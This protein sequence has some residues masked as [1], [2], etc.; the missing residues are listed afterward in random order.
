MGRAEVNR[1][2]ELNLTLPYLGSARRTGW[3]AVEPWGCWT[4]SR[5]ATLTFATRLPPNTEVAIY[6]SLLLPPG[7]ASEKVSVKIDAGGISSIIRNIRTE[8]CWYVAEGKTGPEG[9]VSIILLS[10]GPFAKTDKGEAFVGLGSLAYCES[11]DALARVKFFEK[12]TLEKLSRQ[13]APP[14]KVLTK[15]VEIANTAKAFRQ[16]IDFRGQAMSEVTTSRLVFMHIPKTG[17]TSLHEVLVAQFK[18][19]EICPERFNHL[20]EW[21]SSDLAKF[22]LF[23]GHFDFDSISL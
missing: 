14:A 15:V 17:G 22:R 21:A 20:R 10:N 18:P 19:G 23:S 13:V 4:S 2:D 6:L 9:E 7:T 11:S 5:R 8:E 3:N 16:T 1:R 12:I